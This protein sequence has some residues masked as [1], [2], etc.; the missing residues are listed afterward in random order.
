VT[1][2]PVALVTCP[3]GRDDVD[4]V[5]EVRKDLRIAWRRSM[6]QDVTF[7]LRQLV[8]I[9]ERALSPGVND[10]TTAVQVLNQLHTIL[11]RMIETGE[12]STRMRDEDGQIRLVSSE[13]SF[14]Q[15]LDLCVDEI[16]H[17]GAA[18]VQI[19]ARLNQML[20]QL[21]QIA[22]P[23]QREKLQAKR[24]AVESQVRQARET[25]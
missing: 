17:W 18:S 8:D 24:Y 20:I 6:D 1:S 5:A 4:W 7:G 10:P 11:H 16:A 21:E 22:N 23:A 25:A 2:Q 14:E 3:R 12:V 15:Y 13:W 9:G 19:P